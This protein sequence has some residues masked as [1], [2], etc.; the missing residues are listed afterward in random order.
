MGVFALAEVFLLNR[1]ERIR[2][3]KLTEKRILRVGAYC[4]VSTDRED[5]VN[6]SMRSTKPYYFYYSQT[7]QPKK[8]E[9][10][11][12]WFLLFQVHNFL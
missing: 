1:Y 10:K 7:P 11:L 8:Q 3:D 12:I 9:P 6:H 2:Q 5:Q 4:R